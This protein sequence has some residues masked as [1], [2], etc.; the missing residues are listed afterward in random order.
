MT[1]VGSSSGFAPDPEL[2]SVKMNLLTPKQPAVVPVV[3][4]ELCVS[5]KSASFVRHFTV[6]VSGTPLEGNFRVGQ[7]FG[8]LPPGLDEDGKAHKVRLYSICSPSL[9]EDGA[10]KI[11]ATPVKRLIDEHWD[12]H[13]LFLGVASNY[14][15]NLRPGDEVAITGPSGRRF[16]LPDTTDDHDYLFIST[17]TGIAPFRGMLMELLE[18]DT[19]VN[20]T[21]ISGSA[22][23]KDLLYDAPLLD[24]SSQHQNLRYLTATSR[25]V[26]SGT[27]GKMYVTD[28]LVSNFDDVS[29]ILCSER[30]LVYMC[31]IKG[32]E[33]GIYKELAK[34]LPPEWLDRYLHIDPQASIDIDDWDH[35]FVRSHVRPTKRVFLEVY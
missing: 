23:A 9:G 2:P 26:Q 16:L 25:E 7:A 10:G 8:I 32:M 28:R 33:I 30:G 6:D 20:I 22:Y 34:R 19:R 17:G 3:A 4:N 21:L 5:A 27:S 29:P 11:F 13:S 35:A 31:G 1:D 14:L 24:M 15:C 12:D 18:R